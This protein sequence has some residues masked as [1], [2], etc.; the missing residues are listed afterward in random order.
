MATEYESAISEAQLNELSLLVTSQGFTLA[1]ASEELCEEV[2]DAKCCLASDIVNDLD[3]DDSD[4]EV[5][6]VLRRAEEGASE[7]NNQG[8]QE[9][10]RYLY[11][12]NDFD[13]VKTLVLTA[14]ENLN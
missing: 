3:D 5:E 10:I 2:I 11:D 1:E 9:Q 8:F 4:D 12:C 14:V 6:H 13:I 7:I